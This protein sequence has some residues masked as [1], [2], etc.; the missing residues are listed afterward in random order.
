MVKA[1]REGPRLSSSTCAKGLAE[2]HRFSPAGALWLA[3]SASMAVWSKR[4]GGSA[5]SDWYRS[6][7]LPVDTL[8]RAFKDPTYFVLG[9]MRSRRG[10]WSR[11]GRGWARGRSFGPAGGSGSAGGFSFSPCHRLSSSGPVLSLAMC[12]DTYTSRVPTSLPAPPRPL[13]FLP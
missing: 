13:R 11:E 8:R 1:P 6:L 12:N 10:D 5:D 7:Y 3:T 4:Q 9:E 2:P